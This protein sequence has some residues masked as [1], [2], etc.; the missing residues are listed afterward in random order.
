M[1]NDKMPFFGTRRFDVHIKRTFMNQLSNLRGSNEEIVISE[2]GQVGTQFDG[3][4]HQIHR[5]QLLQLLQD[6][7]ERDPLGLHEARRPQCRH[8]DDARRADRRR[9]PQGRRD[10]AA[11]TTRSPS[12]TSKARSRSRTLTLQPG[13]AVLINTGWGSSGPRTTRAT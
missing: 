13:D 10:A 1:L 9:R 8:A 3:F 2:I 11:T 4:A 6:R 5:E 7:R 12:R